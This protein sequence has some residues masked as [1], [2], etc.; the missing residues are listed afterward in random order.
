MYGVSQPYNAGDPSAQV[1]NHLVSAHVA[2]VARALD[3][4]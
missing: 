1:P 3:A 2:R 4:D